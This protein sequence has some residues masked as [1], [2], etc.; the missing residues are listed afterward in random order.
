M[1]RCYQDRA[2]STM[3][4]VMFASED[5]FCDSGGDG[6][7]GG[8]GDEGSGDEGSDD[9]D[10]RGRGRGSVRADRDDDDD[11]SEYLSPI[12]RRRSAKATRRAGGAGSS[13]PPKER[14]NPVWKQVSGGESIEE[15]TLSPFM[16]RHGDK[17]VILSAVPPFLHCYTHPPPPLRPPRRPFAP[18]VPSETCR[19][20]RAQALGRGFTKAG[21][22]KK[23]KGAN[24]QVRL[25]RCMY[26]G[27]TAMIRV[28]KENG[29]CRVKESTAPTMLHNTHVEEVERGVPGQIA[30]LISPTK[31]MCE[32]RQL[33]GYL[34]KALANQRAAA[35]G[36]NRRQWLKSTGTAP[37]S[38]TGRR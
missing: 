2:L 23:G 24:M 4:S 11:F 32:P 14:T 29:Y 30:A 37:L 9:E 12:R 31:W 15:S 28:E 1:P 13:K 33:R 5:G 6:S 3:A 18:H 26:R 35:R 38:S 22:W 25:Y 10:G 17:V 16:K 20:S 27:C 34:R 7:E 36:R 19:L 21:P 8:S